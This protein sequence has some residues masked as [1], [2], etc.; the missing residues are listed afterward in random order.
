MGAGGGLALDVMRPVPEPPA[1]AI[2]MLEAVQGQLDGA[3]EQM[4]PASGNGWSARRE[5]HLRR[6]RRGAGAHLLAHVRG[7]LVELLDEP[8][9]VELE[10]VEV[11][12]C[13]G[14][15]PGRPAGGA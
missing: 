1:A 9:V 3:R 7:D 8:V 15:R 5:G 2:E 12:H 10:G 14:S 6:F 11:G 13:R 4:S